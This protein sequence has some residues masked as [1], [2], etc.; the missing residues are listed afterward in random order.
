MTNLSN[1]QAL[2][3]S[4]FTQPC[5]EL[6]TQIATITPKIAAELIAQTDPTVQRKSKS[7]Q[8]EFLRLQILNNKWQLNGDAIRQDTKGNIIDGLHRLKACVAA[9]MA[10]KT[11]FVQGLPTDAIKT[12][13][14]SN[15]KRSLGDYI[16]ITYGE[17]KY[18]T[19][20]AAVIQTLSEYAGGRV[21]A[22]DSRQNVGGTHGKK[23][24]IDSV[25]IDD[26]LAKNPNFF[27]FIGHSLAIRAQGDKM[28]TPKVLCS[29]HWIFKQI[30]E[31]KADDFIYK[32]STGTTI[33]TEHPIYAL[34]KRIFKSKETKF[35]GYQKLTARNMACIVFS[36]WN[37]YVTGQ[38]AKKKFSFSKIPALLNGNLVD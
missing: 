14:Q 36:T 35:S 15:A 10:I 20:A 5:T 1:A 37:L 29:F 30:N 2:N 33:S 27:G 24:K 28:L 13:D 21:S 6:T 26:F 32:L 34:R 9:D 38:P 4:T 8:I 11:I 16:G 7:G 18:H 3:K 31:A 12:I 23:H 25:Y 17:A 22:F 19:T